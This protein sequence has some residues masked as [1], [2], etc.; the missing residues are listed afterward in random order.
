VIDAKAA[1]GTGFV[2]DEAET[3]A[4]YR[5]I[6]RAIDTY[7]D[8][9]KFQKLQLN[10]MRRDVGWSNSAQRYLELYKTMMQ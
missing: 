6:G 4:L 2:F 7:R 5:T 3:I 9:K 1:G 10:G 8:H